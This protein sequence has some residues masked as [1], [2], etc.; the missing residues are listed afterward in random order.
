MRIEVLEE[1][2]ALTIHRNV[3]KT[4]ALFNISQPVLSKHVLAAEKE[5]GFSIFTRDDGF[6]PTAAGANFVAGVQKVMG[7]YRALCAESLLLSKQEPPVRLCATRI[8]QFEKFFQDTNIPFFLVPDDG[9][10]NRISLL[11]SGAID[12]AF[13]YCHDTDAIRKLYDV[14]GIDGTEIFEE[15]QTIVT[16]T[17]NPLAQHPVAVSDLKGQQFCTWS[18]P[19]VDIAKYAI[20]RQLGIGPLNWVNRQELNVLNSALYFDFGNMLFIGA[21]EELHAM[22]SGR[23]DI[24]FIDELDGKPFML[25]VYCLYQANSS[26]SNVR[27]LAEALACRPPCN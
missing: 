19:S 21:Y 5:L 22:L 13:S 12:L 23:D 20:E 1:I 7:D 9:T 8:K 26:N 15:R 10:R 11:E 6:Q 4:A 27:R 24:A 17:D 2:V 16:C 25:K 14:P 3:S 18:T